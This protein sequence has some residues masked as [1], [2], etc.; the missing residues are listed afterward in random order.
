[1]PY[2]LKKP[3]KVPGCPNLTD[4]MYCEIHQRQREKDY[5]QY[6]RDPAHKERYHSGAWKKIRA[7]KLN[8]DPL[9]EECMKAGRY[10]KA[11]LVHH[12]LPLSEGGDHRNENL[13]SLCAACHNRIHLEMRNANRQQPGKERL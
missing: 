3:C 8:R 7:A 1:M 12:R 13:E 6:Q 9:C 5:D 4:G 10:T 2:K 11:T